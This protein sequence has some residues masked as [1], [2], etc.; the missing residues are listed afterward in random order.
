MHD[1]RDSDMMQQSQIYP[2]NR[3]RILLS[4]MTALWG[5]VSPALR[6]VSIKWNEKMIHLFF[7]YDGEISDEDQESAECIATELIAHFPE[8]ELEVDVIRLDY[9]KPLPKDKG[10]L[11]YLRKE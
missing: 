3:S 8:H 9:P 4:M 7:F 6:S 5:E 11:V 1:M 10:E 2:V